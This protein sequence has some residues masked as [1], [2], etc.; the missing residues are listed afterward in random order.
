[1]S[2]V[3]VTAKMR[4]QPETDEC[5]ATA[6]LRGMRSLLLRREFYERCLDERD[7]TSVCRELLQTGYASDLQ[8]GALHGFTA[9]FVD[10]ALRENMTRAYG[11][12]LGFM[13]PRGREL[14]V[15]L[16]ARWDVF[17]IKAILRGA[18]GHVAFEQVDDSFFPAGYLGEDELATLARL[19]DVGAAIDTLAMWRLPYAVPLRHAYPEYA[20]SGDLVAM[21]LALD[22]QYAAWAASRLAGEGQGVAVARRI[23]GMQI[24]TANLVTVFRLLAVDADS[25]EAARH[26]LEGGLAVRL[27][28]FLELA[29]LDDADAVLDRLRRTPYALALD[30]AAIRYLATASVSVF[31]RALEE[32]L[33]RAAFSASIRD[34]GGVGV[35]I[36]YLYGKSN[37]ITNVRIIAKGKA[38][39]IPAERLREELIL[40]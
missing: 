7:L 32:L 4:R 37:E 40:V 16:L 12:V 33:V 31:E 10:E 11:K 25:A 17:N 23:L 13:D 34:S 19:D 14:L 9:G 29:G 27:P 6:R 26:F 3:V 5:Y 38:V 2:K 15:T 22:R 18:H 36:S 28:L 8:A 1:M 21:E 35:A 39:G 24:D 20:R 30:E